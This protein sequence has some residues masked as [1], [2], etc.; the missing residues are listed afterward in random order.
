VPCFI[1]LVLK[2]KDKAFV[3]QTISTLSS[4]HMSLVIKKIAPDIHQ[5][6]FKIST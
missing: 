4:L 3:R 5:G 6:Q 1:N 2:I